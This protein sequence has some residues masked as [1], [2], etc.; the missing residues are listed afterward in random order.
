[1]TE[2][3]YHTFIYQYQIGNTK[4]SFSKIKALLSKNLSEFE[5]SGSSISS[6]YE[7]LNFGLIDCLDNNFYS[8]TSTCIFTNLNTNISLAINLPSAIL[9]IVKNNVIDTKLGLTIFHNK[10]FLF[11]DDISTI[12]F[13]MDIYTRNFKPLKK[14][15]SNW[16][17]K[18]REEIR[19]HISLEYYDFSKYKWMQTSDYA[20]DYAIF[21]RYSINEYFFDYIFKFRDKFYEL[22]LQDSEKVRMILLS[23]SS[24]S[25]LKYSQENGEVILKP[26]FRYPHF[27]YKTLTL[28]HILNTGSFPSKKKFKI[29]KNNFLLI[30]KRLQLNYELI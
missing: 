22:N 26:Y 20:G 11:P 2:F 24:K 25:L 7:L 15:V 4:I 5:E 23:N 9:E 18:S 28:A 29:T 27:F 19:G 30:A 16:T 13:D 1:M 3:L 14:I 6:F 21:K 17:N 8:L 10:E 12:Y